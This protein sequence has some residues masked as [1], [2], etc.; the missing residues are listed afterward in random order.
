MKP[1]IMIVDDNKD[2]A[3]SVYEYFKRKDFAVY[4]SYDSSLAVTM[5]NEIKPDLISFTQNKAKP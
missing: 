1:K 5:I 3:R 2:F 4:A